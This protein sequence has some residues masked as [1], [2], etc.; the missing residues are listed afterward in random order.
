MWTKCSTTSII[1]IIITTENM[2][3]ESN[4]KP[5]EIFFK[6]KKENIKIKMTKSSNHNKRKRI[7]PD[8]EKL[9]AERARARPWEWKKKNTLVFTASDAERM[10]RGKKFSEACVRWDQESEGYS[11]FQSWVSLREWGRELE[12]VRKAWD[13]L[14]RRQAWEMRVFRRGVSL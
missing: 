13:E 2:T 6:K 3:K 9:R 8:I 12:T 7:L 5:R 10:R 1:I 14:M 4:M 11:W